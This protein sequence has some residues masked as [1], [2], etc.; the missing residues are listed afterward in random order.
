MNKRNLINKIIM[1]VLAGCMMVSTG[2]L[3]FT[4]ATV[5]AASSSNSAINSQSQE[6]EA[7]EERQGLTPFQQFEAQLDNLVSAGTIA[8]D[9]ETKI[10]DYMKQKSMK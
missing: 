4:Q 9:V 5:N 10:I 7:S 6:P 2:T 3:P 1:G 8:E